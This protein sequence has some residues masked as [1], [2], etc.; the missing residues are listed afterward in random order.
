[1]ESILLRKIFSYFCEHESVAFAILSGMDTILVFRLRRYDSWSVKLT[2]LMSAAER[3]GWQIQVVDQPATKSAIRKLLD[4]W[5]PRGVVIAETPSGR[6]PRE[7]FQGIPTVFLDCEPK[8]ATEGIPNVLHDTRTICEN[9]IRILLDIGCAEIGYVGWFERTFWCE[10][11]RAACRNMLSLLRKRY[12]EMI[13]N[14]REIK[15]VALLN[16]HLVSW[17][18]SL[19]K[20]CGI[21]ATNRIIA[22]QVLSAAT[23]CGLDIPF[24]LAILSID[25]DAPHDEQHSPTISSMSLNYRTVAE[26]TLSLLET[27]HKQHKAQKI[28]VNS[29]KYTQRQSTRRFK[30]KDSEVAAAVERIR[31]KACLGLKPKDVFKDFP[32]SLRSAELRFKEVTGHSAWDEISNIRFDR[33]FELL[34]NTRLPVGALADLCGF[35]STLVMC[36]QFKARTGLTPL[37]WRQKSAHVSIR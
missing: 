14:K 29:F 2:A 8:F 13:P 5:H 24:D 21:L 17:L 33:L 11:K 26:E 10:D 12:F 23:A 25:S 31:Q 6:L 3:R 1:M 15:D 19:T 27:G 37:K 36:R 20:P 34:A 32:C 16:E 35:P 4:F 18:Q 9:A 28:L 22:E 7:I 30:R